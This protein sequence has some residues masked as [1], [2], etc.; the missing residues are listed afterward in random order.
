ISPE[1]EIIDILTSDKKIIAFDS[2]KLRYYLLKWGVETESIV[3]DTV[4][5]AYVLNS[6]KG[7]YNYDDIAI[8]W[9]NTDFPT[10]EILFGKGKSKTA[11]IF[12]DKIQFTA[13][14]A[15]HSEVA[16]KSYE[17][18]NKKIKENEQEFLYYNI[19]LP[20]A[21][22]LSSM[23]TY[24]IKADRESLVEYDN[25][26]TKNIEV[27]KSTVYALAGEEFNI[28]SPQQLGKVLFENLGLKGGKKT[29][30]GYSTAAD[31]LDKIKSK[32]PVVEKVLNYRT[33]TKLKSTYCDGL[34]NVMDK[35]TGRI[36]S[37]FNQTIT[38][39]GRLSS[40][41]PNLQNI[42]VRTELGRLL[43]KVFVPEPG[44][45]FVDADYSQIELR[46]LAHMSGDEN[47]INAF[48]NGDDIHTLTASQV[49]GISLS[50]V[51]PKMRS[52]AKAVNFG[53][54]YGI[55]AFSL[56]DDLGITVK[57]AENY[58]N[59][60]LTKYA[61][62]RQFMTDSVNFAKET[63]YAKTMY[64][65]RREI[66]ELK[67]PNFNTRSF[68]ER[69]AMNMPI[70]GSAADIMKLAMIRVFKRLKYEGLKS[71]IIL[72]V[73]DEILVET[74]ED[75]RDIV[76]SLVKEEME[77]AATLMV[78]ITADV[79]IGRNWYDTK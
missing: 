76:C 18:L 40:T 65:R 4:L 27:L 50:G 70:Q 32:H 5:A 47:M 46:I 25:E 75:E 79:N 11:F 49:H 56:S 45:L 51:T 2:K 77:A 69:A 42:P 64:N 55:G 6:A 37:T 21:E 34:L 72:Q 12:A 30:T 66:T 68:G 29:K 48:K 20:T 31:V 22:V 44:F 41:E 35:K 58:I 8:D 9:L 38:S 54:V 71:R 61:N 60:Y 78:P 15:R 62:V 43:R 73:H 57:E 52:E 16:W 74:A 1:K 63:G 28:N 23:E 39:T 36:Y 19:E 13:F 17:I 24:G 14:S 3:F 10:E 59:A 7:S 33:L 67:S 26:L 53:I